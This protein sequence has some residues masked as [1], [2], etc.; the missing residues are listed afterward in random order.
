[1]IILDKIKQLIPEGGFIGGDIYLIVG[2]GGLV[3]H[4]YNP[5]GVRLCKEYKHNDEIPVISMKE[6]KISI[7]PFLHEIWIEPDN[8]FKGI[9]YIN[10]V[11][12]N[13]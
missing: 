2:E 6:N 12:N 1:M 5:D 9:K 11:N 13:L 4:K 8:R 3:F 7:K 10:L